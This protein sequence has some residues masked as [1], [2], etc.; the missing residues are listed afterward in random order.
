MAKSVGLR[1]EVLITLT[2]LLGAAL[3]LGGVMMLHLM[4]KNLLEE[5][6]G[7]LR[8]FAQVLATVSRQP[9]GDLPEDVVLE[10]KLVLLAQ[11][12]DDIHCDAWWLYDR[13][14][15]SVGSSVTGQVT[16]SLA[17]RLQMVKL[18]KKLQQKTNYST[19]LSFFEQVESTTQLVLP[20][21]FKNS[22]YGVMELH[23]SLA[24][25]R[26]KILGSL[27][28]LILYIVLYGIVLV[29][30]GYYLILKNIIRPAQNLLKATQD[31]SSGNLETRLPI[32]GPVEISQLATAYNQMVDALRQ[33]HHETEQYI[34][35][36]E[37]TNRELQ[38]ARDEL[39]RS[40]KMASVGQLA[41]GL[42]HEIGNPLAA[43]IGYLDLLKQRIEVASDSDILQ[44]ALVEA[45]RIDFL[46][47]E[48][49]D[50]SR[51][52]ANGV[53]EPVDIV[54]VMRSCVQLLNNQG[55]LTGVDVADELPASLPEITGDANKFQQVFIN[56]LLN[57]IQACEKNVKITLMAGENSTNIWLVI[58]DNGSGIAKENLSRIFDPFY[59]TKAPGEGTGLGLAICQRIIE[60]AGGKIEI[61]SCVGRGSSFKLVFYGS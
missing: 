30:A 25:I 14:F 7:Q 45:N 8:S 34:R 13:N 46:V 28:V 32:A 57:A 61:E 58:K 36:L 54:K 1:T 29:L 31:V 37:Q 33:S 19:L 35:S 50:F 20:I 12:P 16:P 43:I 15:N 22:F 5:R 51:P 23:F 41:A 52:T 55:T 10:E 39:I 56:L 53:T 18:T 49:L 44:R 40:E 6:V 9:Q 38:Q 26:L 48:L 3:V 27:Q 21:Q 47:R 11:L 60:E 4:E 24:D 59:T 17:A 42:A 2:L